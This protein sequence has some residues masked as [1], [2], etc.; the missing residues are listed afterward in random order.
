MMAALGH[1]AAHVPHPLHSTSLM[2]EIFFSSSKLIAEREQSVLQIRQPAHFS[3]STMLVADSTSIS[4]L[5]I[6][7]WTAEAA[8]PAWATVSGNILGALAG[9][10]NEDS[11]R[12]GRHGSKLWV[13]FREERAIAAADVESMGDVLGVFRRLQTVCQDDHVQRDPAHLADQSV[14]H[15]HNQFP[16][17]LFVEW[18]VRDRCRPAANE[19]DLFFEQAMIELL[20]SFPEAAHVDVEVI[21][22]R[23][24]FFFDQV[25][26]FQS[27]HAAD[28]GAIFVVA[29][30]PASDAVN[31]ADAF[32]SLPV[33]EHDLA[34]G[35]TRGAVHLFEVQTGQHILELAVA[36]FRDLF[37]V[38][39]L[40]SG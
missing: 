5:E 33:G 13:S 32:R 6:R 21:H 30:V 9:P 3:A 24:G 39:L 29:L 40:E 28:P 11:V 36:V 7:D 4:P 31:D 1:A 16:D 8:A 26:E 17:F 15:P 12:C 10:G 35:R 20:V 34:A 14:F 38:K 18:E 37:G 25:S 2:T 22:I 23:P 27:V 19:A